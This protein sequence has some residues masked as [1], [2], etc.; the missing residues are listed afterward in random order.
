M[1]QAKQRG[2]REERIAQS[3]AVASM[4][5][6]EAA[7]HAVATAEAN[8]QH[9][10]QQRIKQLDREERARQL[11]SDPRTAA[12]RAQAASVLLMLAAATSRF[13]LKAPF[14]TGYVEIND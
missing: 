2:T 7:A 10:A 8:A 4:R 9:A 12:A 1:G 14:D 3:Q 5:R 6:D 13:P 11:R